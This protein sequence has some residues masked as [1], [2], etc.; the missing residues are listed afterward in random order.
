VDTS[1]VAF[2]AVAAVCHAGWN[3]ALKTAGDPRRAATI[4]MSAASAVGVPLVVVSWLAVGR[5]AIPAQAWLL[6]TV[7]GAVEVV[8]FVFLAAAYRRG[9]LSLV[10]PLAR[11]T[12]PLL[13]VAIGVGVLG[14]RLAPAA[15]LGVGLLV[16]GVLLVQRPWRLLSTAA[17]ASD[18]SAAGFALLTGMTIATYTAID[19]VGVSLTA[20]WIY[21]GILFPVGAIGLVAFELVD[22]RMEPRWGERGATPP[23]GT[24]GTTEAGRAAVAGLLMFA[25]YGL[26]LAALSRAPLALVA[27][28]RESA[29]LLTATWGVARLGEAAARG[30]VAL[31]LSGSVLVL[32]GAAALAI[33]R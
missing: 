7:S 2:V 10:Y 26:V 31:R 8:Y 16:G 12:A 14:E 9:D 24:P 28:L 23:A 29:V 5:P 30:E 22:R 3:I 33:A 4:G 27:P 6:G 17:D 19:S 25:G 20:P 15:W 18:R 21:A 11:G 1:A 32:A 13:A